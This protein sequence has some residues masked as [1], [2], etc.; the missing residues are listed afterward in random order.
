MKLLDRYI[1]RQY[2]INIGALLLILAC[3][4]VCID[5]SLNLSRYW[6]VA[7]DV[8]RQ[9]GGVDSALRRLMITLLLIADLWWPRLLSLFAFLNGLV[10]IGA[11]GFTVTQMVRHRELVAVLTS[12]QS[13]YRVARPILLVALL[14]T[15]MQVLDQELIIPRIAPLLTREQGDAGRRS[16]GSTRVPPTVDAKGRILYAAT[17][18]ADAGVLTDLYIWERGD[19]GLATRRVHANRAVW[20]GGAWDLEGATVESRRVGEKDPGP[21]PTRIGT[22]LDPTALKMKRFAGYGN[23]ISF[24]Q[25]RQMLAAINSMGTDQEQAR[26]MRDQLERASLGRVSTMIANLLTLVVAMSFFLTREPRNML[27]Q[28]LK[29]APVGIVSLIGVVVGTSASAPGVPTSLSVFIPVMVLLPVA[30][31]MVSRVRS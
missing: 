17:F 5:V 13:L 7:V 29:C 4:V 16:L 18:D 8:A 9:P 10:L 3:F 2:L 6:N 1:A 22:N 30:I 14:M 21:P 26:K 25:A 19:D 15:G 31:A 11:M 28:S 23:N 27:L 24:A 20:R 12:G